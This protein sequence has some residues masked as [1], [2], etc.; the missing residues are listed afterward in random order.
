MDPPEREREWDY[1][2]SQWHHVHR[3]RRLVGVPEELLV[4][5]SA[6]LIMVRA[7]AFKVYVEG[8]NLSNSNAAPILRTAG[9]RVEPTDPSGTGSSVGQG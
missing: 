9:C 5:N 4:G 2:G 3:N 1:D 8:K 7:R 6:G